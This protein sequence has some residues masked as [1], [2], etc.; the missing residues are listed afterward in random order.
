MEKSKRNFYTPSTDPDGSYT[1]TRK[2]EYGKE[3]L[4]G[5]LPADEETPVQDVDDL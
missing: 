5:I 2:A 1:G 3:I 4:P